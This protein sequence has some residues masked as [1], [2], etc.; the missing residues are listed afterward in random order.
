MSGRL[1]VMSVHVQLGRTKM[2]GRKRSQEPAS[3]SS[4]KKAKRQVTKATFNK[5]QREHDREHQTLSW[6]R[7]EMDRDNIHVASLHCDLCKKYEGHLQS[8][9]SFNAAWITGSTNQKVSNV[10]D[11]AGSEVH[12]AAMSRKRAESAKARGE[13]AVL[14]SPIGCAL[15]ILDSTTRAR[16][17]R[18]FDLCFMMAKE[19]IALLNIR[20]CW[21]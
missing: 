8:L 20:P 18:I 11:H 9:K 10:V 13:S 5:W 4:S 21:S 15:S 2:T 7:C 16:M 14:T 17:G 19:S 3:A 1:Q 12:K 6:L